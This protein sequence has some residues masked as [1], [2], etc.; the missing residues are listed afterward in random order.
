[1]YKDVHYLLFS[2]KS[3]YQLLYEG[4]YVYYGKYLKSSRNHHDFPFRQILLNHILSITQGLDPDAKFLNYL[5]G[6]NHQEPVKLQLYLIS[7]S[8]NH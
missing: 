6:P 2:M 5:V 1:M 8:Y 3:S 4:P 7:H